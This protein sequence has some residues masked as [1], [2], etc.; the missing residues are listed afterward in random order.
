MAKKQNKIEFSEQGM[1]SFKNVTDAIDYFKKFGHKERAITLLYNHAFQLKVGNVS[2]NLS[3]IDKSTELKAI[4]KAKE[5]IDLF[6]ELHAKWKNRF[7]VEKIEVAEQIE[8]EKIT[9]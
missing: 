1:R 3:G 4:F 7:Q 2:V 9:E 8:A 6:H 5:L